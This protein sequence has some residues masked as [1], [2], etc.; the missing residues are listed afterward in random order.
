MLEYTL[1]SDGKYR[2]KGYRETQDDLTFNGT[3]V[4][5]GVSFVVVVEFNKLK[6]A[7]KS[8]KNRKKTQP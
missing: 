5:T 3:V 8:R 7:F 6:N 2:I 4:E 1:T